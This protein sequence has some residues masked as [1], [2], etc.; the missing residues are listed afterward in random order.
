MIWTDQ[1]AIV[2]E[3]W[4]GIGV[5]MALLPLMG[6]LS[7]RLGPRPLLISSCIGYAVRG[8]PFS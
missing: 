1:V 7:D 4:R 8:Y 3:G 2:S 5:F 6:W